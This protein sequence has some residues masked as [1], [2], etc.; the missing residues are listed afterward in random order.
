MNGISRGAGFDFNK[1]Q[2]VVVTADQVDF[3]PGC[4][5]I[6]DQHPITVTA[7][8]SGRNAFSVSADLRRGR[9]LGRGRTFVSVETFAD[10]LGKVREG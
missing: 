8:E 6:A 10:V 9:Q 5:V 4:L 1:N 7:Y 3:A 2:D